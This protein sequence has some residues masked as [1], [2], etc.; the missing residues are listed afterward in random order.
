MSNLLKSTNWSKKSTIMEKSHVKML[1]RKSP[2]SIIPSRKR[3]KNLWQFRSF[4][5]T[6]S[7]TIFPTHP[8][9]FG[10]R[11]WICLQCLMLGELQYSGDIHLLCG[12]CC[13]CCCCCC[14]R[15]LSK[16]KFIHILKYIGFIWMILYMYVAVGSVVQVSRRY[17]HR[18]HLYMVLYMRW[19][20]LC[21]GWLDAVSVLVV[22]IDWMLS[23]LARS[24]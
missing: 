22:E 24:C 13:C 4:P 12:C 20:S 7:P 10:V 16:V 9:T 19:C 17:S 6:R 3:R 1:L 2:R 15:E 11:L 14:R 18:V 8:I 23:A 5:P 21:N